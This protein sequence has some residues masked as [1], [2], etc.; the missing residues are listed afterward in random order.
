MQPK[1]FAWF[2][3]KLNQYHRRMILGECVIEARLPEWITK[4]RY[5]I[6][7]KLWIAGE[8]FQHSLAVLGTY[9]RLN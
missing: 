4:N 9:H 3:K 7:R 5:A 1:T 2:A 8:V 6:A